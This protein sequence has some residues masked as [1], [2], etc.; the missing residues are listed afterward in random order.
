[1]INKIIGMIKAAK[2][3]DSER[4]GL[5]GQG[6]KYV[7]GDLVLGTYS[8]FVKIYW[9]GVHID[10]LLH[11]EAELVRDALF[12]RRKELKDSS[13]KQFLAS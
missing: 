7:I 11:A 10:T 8:G 6:K 4:Y 9:S 5:D 3:L 13:L 1:M 12:D 2:K